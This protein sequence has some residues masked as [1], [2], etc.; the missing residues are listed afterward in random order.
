MGG[1]TPRLG[2]FMSFYSERPPIPQK[3]THA[4]LP[5]G[6]LAQQTDKE[7]K[8]GVVREVE[9]GIILD[10][11]TATALVVWLKQQLENIKEIKAQTQLAKV[12][13]TS[14]QPS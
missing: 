14:G 8:E 2:V 10:E 11:A 13:D 3:V 9:A 7:G 4:V 1:L 12:K 5:S 6:T